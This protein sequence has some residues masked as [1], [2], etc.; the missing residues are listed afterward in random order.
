MPI[1]ESLLKRIKCCLSKGEHVS[2]DLVIVVEC[3]NTAFKKCIVGSKYEYID[4]YGCK[5]KH[6]KTSLLKAPDN[7]FVEEESIKCS[8]NDLFEYVDEKLKD[9][10]ENLKSINNFEII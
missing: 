5:N 7:K 1:T 10:F 9:S 6:E 8:L 2:L 3:Q 4:C